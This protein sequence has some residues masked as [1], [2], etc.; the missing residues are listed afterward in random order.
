LDK[1]I[2]AYHAKYGV[3]LSLPSVVGRD[4]V[5]RILEPAMSDDERRALSQSAE[6]LR[7]AVQRT[8]RIT[9]PKPIQ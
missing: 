2:G 5:S 7:Q 1:L 3:T 8:S 6:I 4:G 9:Q